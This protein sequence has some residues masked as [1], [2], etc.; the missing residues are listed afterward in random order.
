LPEHFVITS[1]HVGH[2]IVSVDPA[3]GA[4]TFIADRDVCLSP[5]FARMAIDQ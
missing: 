5:R 1:L 4:M 3:T 2:R